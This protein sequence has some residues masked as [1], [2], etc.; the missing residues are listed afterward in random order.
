[1]RALIIQ[2]GEDEGA[3]HIER[4]FRER[5]VVDVRH[6]WRGDALPD[7][8][9]GYDALVVLGGPMSALDD[10]GHPNLRRESQ[11]L[12]ES[13]RAGRLT[14]GICL[15]AQLFAR[16][17]GARVYTGPQAELGILPLHVNEL[18]MADPL[19]STCTGRSLVQWHR[20]TFELPDG[21]THLASTPLFANQAFRFGARGW[22][23]QFHPE[24]DLAMRTTWARTGAATLRAGGVD[25]ASLT[26][27]ETA[28][29][30]ELGR[31][32]A[33]RL[34]ATL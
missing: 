16:G 29:L 2:H 15:G 22:A 30:D 10:A 8:L 31:A 11:L 27:P 20:D 34:L 26:A 3:G 4:L 21:V 1:M 25:P 7:T 5:G 23:V 24:L 9:D 14:L 33:E 19:L 32:F 6:M 18:G 17:L 13:A 12:V 28:A